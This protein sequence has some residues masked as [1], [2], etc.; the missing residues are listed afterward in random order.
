MKIN[1]LEEIA[2]Q[3]KKSKK[4]AVFCHVR[5]DGDALGSGLAL[6]AA[7]K[8]A[9][10]TAFMC[11]EELPPEKFYFLQAMHGVQTQLP[12][13]DFDTFVSVDCADIQR[14]GCF[15]K[16]FAKFKGT[17]VNIDHHISN[18]GFAEYNYVEECPATCQLLTRILRCAQLE[19]DEEVANLLMLGLIT[20]S[21]NFTHTDVSPETYETA[22]YL[23][24]NGANMNVINYEM[25][26]RQSKQRALLYGRAMNK[27]RFALDDKLAIIIVTEK[28]LKETGAEKNMTEGFVDFPLTIDG[29]EVAVSLME[30]REGMYKTSLRSKGNVN[31]NAIATAFGGGGHVL[32]SGCMIFGMLEEVIDKLT[33]TVYQH[34]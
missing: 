31:V 9:G 7:L 3:L 26:S 2:Q 19:I 13:V 33:Y 20:D 25:Y 30:Y 16:H 10:K 23:R 1:S 6:C 22:A 21:G 27:M 11:C 17:T 14:L 8:R 15:A 24:G 12:A 4:V 18:A 34:I 5:P 32:A 29:V 28:D